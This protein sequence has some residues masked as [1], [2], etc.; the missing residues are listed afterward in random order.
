[1]KELPGHVTSQFER[2]KFLKQ[3]CTVSLMTLA[4]RDLGAKESRKVIPNNFTWDQNVE[5]EKYWET[6]KKQ[7]TVPSNLVMVNAANLC[8][9]PSF[10]VDRVNDYTKQLGGNV[11]FQY[12]ESLSEQRNK[13]ITM[14]AEFLGVSKP[15]ISITRNT[16]ESNTIIVN[17]FD[18]K[19][20][21]E[22]IIWDQ[23]HPSAGLAF[24]QKA[25]RYGFD[26]KKISVPRNP[27]SEDELI[28]PFEK[29][30]TN[31][32]RL[33]AFSHISNIS[34]IALPMKRIC[35]LAK[36]KKILTLVDGAQSFGLMEMNLKEAGCDFYTASTH[37]WLMG[38]LENGILYV[39]SD[40]IHRI[41]PNVIGGGWKDGTNT[42][43]EKIGVL[44]QRNDATTA[45][46]P[47]IIE[48]HNKIGRKNIEN[49]VVQL[50]TYL[51]QQIKTKTPMAVFNSP[52]NPAASAG[53]VIIGFPGKDPKEMYQRL[54]DQYGIACA[55]TGG[56]R[57]SPTIYNT[58]ADMDKI[59]GALKQ[60]AV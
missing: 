57:F 10:I 19:P 35:R 3:L 52:I 41:W 46:L 36:E 30:I 25:K 56:I 49:R 27:V 17:S 22:V 48:F 43:D 2:R 11:S 20:G 15:E 53:I 4:T 9:S 59:V 18:F 24:E 51:K 58:L 26:L 32:T 39:A 50:T 13:A 31:K 60:L 37:K 6:I 7:F 5:D 12:R 40:Q 23:N 1:M 38:P 33:I 29:A 42:L 16:S 28:G 34:G 21:D 44:G 47:G 14:L 8:P 45:S 54:Y 55:A